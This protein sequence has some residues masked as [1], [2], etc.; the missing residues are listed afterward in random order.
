MFIN[1]PHTVYKLKEAGVFFHADS[2]AHKSYED[3][4]KLI[5]DPPSMVIVDRYARELI[6]K[7][8]EKDPKYTFHVFSS[9]IRYNTAHMWITDPQ[10]KYRGRVPLHTFKVYY[11]DE[12]CVKGKHI[13][14]IESV[15]KFMDDGLQICVASRFTRSVRQN[16]KSTR[17]MNTAVK[18]VLKYIKPVDLKEK[19]NVVRNNTGMA[20]RNAIR[21]VDELDV[22]YLASNRVKVERFFNALI[23][24]HADVFNSI[25]KSISNTDDQ[26]KKIV[27]GY[28][29]F[30]QLR[31]MDKQISDCKGMLVI[32]DGDTVHLSS[33]LGN[34][35]TSKIKTYKHADLSDDTKRDIAMLSLCDRS[36]ALTDVGIKVDDNSFYLLNDGD[37]DA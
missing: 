16:H 30:I 34:L 27:Q 18:N 1:K 13:G 7:V 11:N 23:T 26:A 19:F 5:N 32:K 8:R 25:L 33:F 35:S 3:I 15:D 17:V 31:H 6:Q 36:T 37:L 9:D 12:K 2:H 4:N 24:D 14:E 20:I 29:S 28:E 10:S 21:N 22:V